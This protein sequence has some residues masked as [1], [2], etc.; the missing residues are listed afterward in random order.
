[1]TGLVASKLKSFRLASRFLFLA[2]IVARRY[3]EGIY[4]ELEAQDLKLPKTLGGL[5]M[6]M[7]LRSTSLETI[8]T[9]V[10]SLI[11]QQVC[12]IL[13]E[14]RWT[15]E[16]MV[17]LARTVTSCWL[18]LKKLC[19]PLAT[20]GEG[21]R[22]LLHRWVDSCALR[23]YPR[24]YELFS[25]VDLANASHIMSEWQAVTHIVSGE[26]PATDYIC[27]ADWLR[28]CGNFL[29]QLSCNTI[30]KFSGILE[31][32]YLARDRQQLMTHCLNLSSLTHTRSLLKFYGSR[33]T[34]PSAAPCVLFR[35][36]D[37]YKMQNFL[38]YL[39]SI[40]DFACTFVSDSAV[41]FCS[42]SLL[43]PAYRARFL[44][45]LSDRQEEFGAD[46]VVTCFTS[47]GPTTKLKPCFPDLK[48]LYSLD[49]PA[50]HIIISARNPLA[51]KRFICH[52]LRRMK[53]ILVDDSL[54]S[55]ELLNLPEV[56]SQ[57]INYLLEILAYM[58]VFSHLHREGALD[59]APIV[60]SRLA[61][62]YLEVTLR[63]LTRR[64]LTSRYI[65]RCLWIVS[66]KLISL[67]A[68]YMCKFYR[69]DRLTS[70]GLQILPLVL[71]SRRA[72]IHCRFPDAY[73]SR[74]LDKTL[75]SLAECL[76]DAKTKSVH[77]L[78][79][80][81]A[82][83][84]IIEGCRH[85][86]GVEK[87]FADRPTTG[88]TALKLLGSGTFGDVFRVYDYSRNQLIAL[89][90]IDLQ[91]SAVMREEVLEEVNFLRLFRYNYITKFCEARI[92]GS[93]VYVTTEYSPGL[94]LLKA[95]PETLFQSLGYSN[96]LFRRITIQLLLGLSFLHS[97]SVVHGD[98]KPANIIIDIY[99]RVKLVD[100]GATKALLRGSAVFRGKSGNL[101]LGTM[102][103]MAPETLM[104]SEY[105][106][107]ADIWSLGCT[108]FHMV[109]G[110]APWSNCVLP[111][112]ILYTMKAGKL[113]NLDGLERTSLDSDAKS[114]IKSCLQFDPEARPLAF[115]LLLSPFLFG[116]IGF[117]PLSLKPTW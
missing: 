23:L 86:L 50:N 88:I 89:K 63:F 48:R 45:F 91:S 29:S 22:A 94:T 77:L 21:V 3:T 34:L 14:D 111:W 52:L 43:A 64:K 84:L 87:V 92:V 75:E 32:H 70:F 15:F 115:E 80:L 4:I 96:V 47:L 41:E 106:L 60:T 114:L 30:S 27:N 28:M 33:V 71:H 17:L 62:F 10:F 68:S 54:G 6:A 56:N 51:K 36:E 7:I 110:Q 31:G 8:S 113:F 42:A 24:P 16:N 19:F 49:Y 69:E 20:F 5:L 39:S 46:F 107:R 82:S 66:F 99:E 105:T 98:L 12:K 55:A 26:I 74:A 103:Y 112:G 78:E 44:H 65:S 37:E 2:L 11:L 9:N 35:V 100:F 81:E 108:L 79:D 61:H 57:E 13:K 58:W 104:R 72:I 73:N 40:N 116:P 83:L 67:W 95:V 53:L 38:N 102:E 117:P 85:I 90:Q 109:T 93:K 76:E 18:T 1:M 97:N 25:M 59:L 101:A